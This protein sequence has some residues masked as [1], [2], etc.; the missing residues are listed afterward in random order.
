MQDLSFEQEVSFNGV[1]LSPWLLVTDVGRSIAP[2]LDVTRVEVPG[3]DGCLI[4][5]A[6]L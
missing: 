5:S 2:G 4:S 6:R 3:D 1:D